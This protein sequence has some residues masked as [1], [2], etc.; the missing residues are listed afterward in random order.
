MMPSLL[1]KKNKGPSKNAKSAPASDHSERTSP[2]KRVA[3]SP[4][5]ASETREDAY[6]PRQP[7]PAAAQCQALD[8]PA[9]SQLAPTRPEGGRTSTSEH[10][11]QRPSNGSTMQKRPE[12]GST[13]TSEHKRQKPSTGTSV[14]KR[15]A[16]DDAAAGQRAHKR[17]KPSSTS[18]SAGKR[19]RK[20]PAERDYYNKERQIYKKF[21]RQNFC[22]ARKVAERVL[23]MLGLDAAGQRALCGFEPCPRPTGPQSF[24]NPASCIGTE[25]CHPEVPSLR[26]IRVKVGET[27]GTLKRNQPLKLGIIDK[28]YLAS[29][30]APYYERTA[31][32]PSGSQRASTRF[33][34]ISP[35]LFV[36]VKLETPF[37]GHGLSGNLL[38]HNMP[39]ARAHG[40]FNKLKSQVFMLRKTVKAIC[41]GYAPADIAKV[42]QETYDKVLATYE[43]SLAKAQRERVAQASCADA[44]SSSS[45]SS[46]SES[47][48]NSDEDA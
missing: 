2:R 40:K 39:A 27:V 36:N 13:S 19:S 47:G 22:S 34:H 33:D 44:V 32:A 17:Q 24:Y 43:K 7:T 26:G 12:G 48:C 37:R 3:P 1:F 8:S 28:L 35:E 45:S 23:D 16:S 14:G 42:D 25:A 31:H 21:I 5:S 41:Q 15:Q 46:S 11:R 30:D 29:A 18:T 38:R 4:S 10:K 9:A 20:S 6:S